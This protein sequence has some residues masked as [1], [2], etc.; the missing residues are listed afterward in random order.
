[1]RMAI[2]PEGQLLSTE[3]SNAIQRLK[4]AE[5][6]W[7]GENFSIKTSLIGWDRISDDIELSPEDFARMEDNQLKISESFKASADR[8]NILQ[9]TG[10]ITSDKDL[11]AQMKRMMRGDD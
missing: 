10:F 5:S 11:A 1:M 7:P 6:E 2:G 8:Q 3:M 9:R 4:D